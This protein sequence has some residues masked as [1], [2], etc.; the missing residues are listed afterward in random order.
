V[1][2]RR[3]V[4]IDLGI[5][6]AHTV[7]VLD[8]EGTI[9]AKRKAWPTVESLATVETAAL[10]C[11]PAGTRLEVVIE[12]TRP[13]W[14]PVAVFFTA[15]GHRVFRVSSQKAADLRRFLSRH[16]KSNG[17]DADTLARLP[18]FDPARLRPLALPGAERA[19]LDRRVRVTDRLTRQ[20]ADHK[21]R[22]KDLAR[23]LLPLSPLT[24]ELGAADLAVLECHAGPRA[25]L[26]LSPARLTALIARA[27]HGHQGAGRAR[28][29]LDAARASLELYGSHPAVDLAGLAAE[30]ATEIR[31][32]HAAQAELSAHAA[33][34]ETYY[35][36]VDPAGLARSLPGLAEVGGPALTACM[37]DPA[38]FGRA[39]QF[40]SYT[41]LAP[42]ASETGE[43]DR[44]GQP[45]SKA[46]SSL[47][48]TTLVRAADTARKQDPQ[49]AR[50]YHQQMSQRGKD[51]LGALCVTA[52]SLAE[53]AWT[54]MRRGTPYVICDTD[55]RPVSAGQAKAIIAEHWTVPPEIRTRR[56][57]KK[58]GKAPQKVLA[59]QYARGDLPR[60]TTPP[61]HEQP[62]KRSP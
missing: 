32:L 61:R 59:G 17:I 52:A 1:N 37:G 10:A 5:A 14:L 26:R 46:G 48:R 29:W 62:V 47:L 9:V 16:A 13:A 19:A 43:T 58:T 7:R 60:G 27:S 24:G 28:Q 2:H 54:V 21:R 51:H 56:R 41:G 34:R 22:I 11:C 55:G 49:L 53:R 4:G 12:P 31:L 33:R 40:R 30:V 44:K 3:L 39:S 23:Q 20:A 57:G 8:G 35:R 15:R 38:R 25:L 18:L 50:I 36:A 45:M 42:K 6:T